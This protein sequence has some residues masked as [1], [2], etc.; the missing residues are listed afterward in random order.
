MAVTEIAFLHLKVRQ[1]STATKTG[2]R[3][4]QQAQSKYSGYPVHFLRQVEDPSYFYLLGGWESVAIHGGEWITSEI[5]QRLLGKL[6]VDMDVEWMFHLDVPPSGSLSNTPLQAP[7][8]ML[9][10]YF[11]NPSKKA[12]FDHVFAA[13]IPALEAS[14]CV[15][16]YF[17]GWRIDKDMESEN[18]EF[19][20]L[21]GWKAIEDFH[22]F[23]ESMATEQFM[24][25]Q[26]VATR[27]E[28]K[29][30][31]LEKWE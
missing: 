10:R 5:N 2:L 21:T 28:T 30:L 6:Q 15:S 13:G 4:A 22:N 3:E 18:E 17:G 24:V 31:R 1:P 11:V 27:V 14:T 8:V 23:S 26:T 19:V 25:I 12:K 20:V 7:V 29:H 16:P 9:S